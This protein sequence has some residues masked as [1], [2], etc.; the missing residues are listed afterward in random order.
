MLAKSVI[1]LQP[2][3]KNRVEPAAMSAEHRR[4]AFAAVPWTTNGFRVLEREVP[5]LHLPLHTGDPQQFGDPQQ[6]GGP[7]QTG[8]S[9]ATASLFI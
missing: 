2:V 8:D 7:L 5:I 6:S 9:A 4:T 1:C 3:L